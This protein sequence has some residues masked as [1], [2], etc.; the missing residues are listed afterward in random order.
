MLIDTHCHIGKNDD[1][2]KIIKT[3]RLNGVELIILGGCN[4]D[5]NLYNLELSKKYKN[6]FATIGY[7]PDVC[8]LISSLDLSKLKEQINNNFVVGIGEVGLDYHYS[9]NEKDKQIDLFRKQLDIAK[10]YNLPV[11]I[12]SR[13]ATLDTINVLKNYNLKGIIH[14]F[15]G[16]YETALEYINMGYKLGIGGVVTF[17]NSKLKDVVLKVGLKNI[18]LETD[19][20]YLSPFRGEK[21]VPA[22]VKVIAE[23]LACL[24][25]VSVET[26]EDETCKN[27]FSIFNI[28]CK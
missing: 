25:N 4:Y 8:S 11:V 14:C 6:V 22:N 7:H 3:S 28:D 9:T 17:K 21:N 2:E 1:I 15:S 23:F 16:S 24:F 20:P 12:H 5:D 18:V 19:S 27:V 26:I 10:E 13:D